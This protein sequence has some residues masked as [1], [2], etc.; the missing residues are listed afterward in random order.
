M[1]ISNSLKA[2]LRFSKSSSTVEDLINCAKNMIL[3]NTDINLH[4]RISAKID[5]LNFDIANINESS[6]YDETTNTVYI[7]ANYIT[8][9]NV[10]LHEIMHAIGTEILENCT[11]IGLNKRFF[12]QLD[13]ETKLFSNFGYGANEGLNQFYTETFLDKNIKVSK[14]S[15]EY[16]F[17]SNILACLQDIVGTDN[18]KEA[19]FSGK[20]IDYLI[21]V[22]IKECHLPNENKILKLILQLDFYKKVARTHMIFGAEFS[23]ETRLLL[24]EAYKNL[25]TIALIKA[26][27]ENKNICYTDIIKPYCLIDEN[28][29]YFLKYINNDL[30]KHFYKEKNHIFND[31]SSNFI[32]MQQKP[33]LE[34]AEILFR[35]YLNTKKI[36]GTI[37]PEEIK[38]G[39]FYN[40]ILLNC[41]FYDN[42][43]ISKAIFTSDFQKELTVALFNKENNL[44]PNHDKEKAQLIKQVLS[45]RNVVRCGAEIS[46]D[47]IIECTKDEDFSIFL[48]ET[49][50]SYYKEIFSKIEDN[51]KYKPKLLKFILKE[52]YTSRFEQYK[53]IKSIPQI[54][55]QNEE[56]KK[57]ILENSILST[58]QITTIKE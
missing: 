48:I 9:I 20:G 21:D 39:E 5:N 37:I 24:T 44:M 11:I 46:D 8:D 33:F 40:Y 35:K 7:G 12:K 13:S 41:M 32:G 56:I 58:E 42:N 27:F 38:C 54:Y 36:D 50:P 14:V 45:S 47:I 22:T 10:Y 49:M 4:K 31:I 19:H 26:K 2:F 53:L 17:C 29:Q 28:L 23:P 1:H 18:F 34:Y 55:K 57:T 51:N 25:I 15:T 16:S 43:N 30:I 6:K 52:V 3:N